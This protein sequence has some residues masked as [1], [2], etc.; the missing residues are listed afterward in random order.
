MKISNEVLNVLSNANTNGNHLTLTGQL[1]R[2][3]YQDANKALEAAGGKWN[4]KAKAHV[5]DRDASEAIDQLLLTGEI[6]VPQNFGY[7][8]TP[9]ALVEQMIE[10][11][12][13]DQGMRVLEP[14]AGQGAI[15]HEVIKYCDV[16]CYE[17]LESNANKIAICG[18]NVGDFLQVEPNPIYDRVIMNPPF[19]KQQDIHHV[20]HA[21]KFLKPGGKLV[22]VMSN[23][24]TF[25]DNK[26]TKDFREFVDMH[27]GYIEECPE[28]SFKESGTMVRTVIATL[29][30]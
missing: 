27:G 17:L 18:V 19:S 15:A 4:R 20:L 16:D 22:S 5:F 11:A 12:E 2:K 28:A 25:R 23:S 14:S 10:L 6:T 3:L 7:F 13:L 21:F 24:V 26:L 1:D 8:P 9:K 30:N 29:E